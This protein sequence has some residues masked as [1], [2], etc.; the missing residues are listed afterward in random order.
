MK[1]NTK[2]VILRIYNRHDLDLIA[3]RSIK[4]FDMNGAIKYVLH[5]YISGN[6]VKMQI[7]TI[8]DYTKAKFK[9]SYTIFINLDEEKDS[10]IIAFLDTI[11]PYYKNAAIKTIFRAS[12]LSLPSSVFNKENSVFTNDYANALNKSMEDS[13]SA[14]DFY[15]PVLKKKSYEKKSGK[16]TKT[17][18]SNSK[19]TQKEVNNA[20]NLIELET[21]N[22]NVIDDMNKTSLVPDSNVFIAKDIKTKIFEEAPSLVDNKPTLENIV[23][24]V[25]QDTNSLFG[26]EKPTED[27]SFEQ[28]QYNYSS[29]DSFANGDFNITNTDTNEADSN[30]DDN[31]DDVN[32]DFMNM[33]SSMLNQ[34]W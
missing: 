21:N 26:H 20:K 9:S 14:F 23:D 13:I 18:E 8:P 27:T 3:L 12:L 1:K 7:P 2:K 11:K 6:P 10:D 31:L 17:K 32:M 33:F 25:P 34:N 16:K 22:K 19:I 24:S 29:N 15:K 5:R 30:D 4:E 28:E